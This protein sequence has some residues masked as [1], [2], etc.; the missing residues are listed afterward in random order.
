MAYGIEIENTNGDLQITQDYTNYH[1]IGSGTLTGGCPNT[2]AGQVS[3]TAQAGN[4][5]PLVFV[6]PHADNIYIGGC[7]FG[8][9]ATLVPTGY[10]YYVW[11]GAHDY[12]IY[13]TT[14]TIAVDSSTYGMQVFDGSGNVQYDSRKSVAQVQTSVTCTT[15]W[16]NNS[17]PYAPYDNPFVPI[18]KS[19]TSFGQRPWFC[20][21]NL[22]N[23]FFYG[24]A[25]IWAMSIVSTA[26]TSEVRFSNGELD[27][28][29]TVWTDYSAV[30]AGGNYT[31]GFA[32][33]QCIVPLGICY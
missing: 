24:G 1:L 4:V 3:Y 31:Q 27:T 14:G 29:G 17:A 28:T 21:N 33:G 8:S 22:V 13:G 2:D 18:V 12:R 25:G 5:L 7:F 19:Y 16:P 15:V 9:A 6:R 20:I 23:W 30:G 32:G 10:V 11:Q 26:D